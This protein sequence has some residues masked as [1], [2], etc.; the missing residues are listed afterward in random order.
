MNVTNMSSH[1]NTHDGRV[2]DADD[3][4]HG[5]DVVER[6]ASDLREGESR[7]VDDDGGVEYQGNDEEDGDELSDGPREPQLQVLEGAGQLELVEHR[8]VDVSG[9]K[10]DQR[11]REHASC[12]LRTE[13]ID[14]RRYTQKSD[15]RYV[16]VI[17]SN[18]QSI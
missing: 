2:K 6:E 10:T 5:R 12:V 3:A 9:H 4:D 17:S 7:N 18:C 8:E 14:L 16:T 13:L 15:T 11:C 1:R